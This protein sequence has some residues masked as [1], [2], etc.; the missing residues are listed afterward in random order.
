MLLCSKVTSMDEL[1]MED[2]KLSLLQ[3]Y[4]SLNKLNIILLV[5][6][7]GFEKGLLGKKK[8]SYYQ[9]KFENNSII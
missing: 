2:V 6:H 9:I 8:H 5:L 1:D 4:F 7:R 3:P